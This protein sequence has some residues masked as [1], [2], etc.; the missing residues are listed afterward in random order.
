[1]HSFPEQR[2]YAMNLLNACC[3]IGPIIAPVVAA[4]EAGIERGPRERWNVKEKRFYSSSY[5]TTSVNVSK[6]DGGLG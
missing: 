6:L 1:M 2:T 3:N 5:G 4:S